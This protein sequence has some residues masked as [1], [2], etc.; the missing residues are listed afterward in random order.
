MSKRKY[1]LP[2]SIGC[3]VVGVASIVLATTLSKGSKSVPTTIPVDK[4]ENY[5]VGS[6]TYDGKT[7]M[8]SASE[9]YDMIPSGITYQEG[10]SRRSP[11]AEQVIS[12]VRQ[13]I[14]SKIARDNG[15]SVS[16]EEVSEAAQKDS[17]GAFTDTS[18]RTNLLLKKLR[19]KV[20]Q[21]PTADQTAPT[22]PAA[23]QENTATKEYADYIV[24]L[25]GD[26]WDATT[27]AWRDQNG[28]IASAVKDLQFSP[29]GAT[30]AAAS[31]AYHASVK[32]TSAEIESA[33]DEWLNYQNEVM[34][35][36]SVNVYSAY[37]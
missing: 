35:N 34:K 26:E 12:F 15:L 14:M 13:T 20:I 30:Y 31:A 36:V 10:E 19:E 1:L 24:S 28:T 2:V 17:H 6:Y 29:T 37:M 22:P 23:G 18:L 32:K 8:V 11:S 5:V 27:G 33:Y 25:A 3:V 4:S 16:D 7:T 9:V 21:V